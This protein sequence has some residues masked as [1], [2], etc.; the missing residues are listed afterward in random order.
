[1]HVQIKMAHP[2]MNLGHPMN[3]KRMGSLCAHLLV[4]AQQRFIAAL[5]A[6]MK[7]GW[8]LHI[9]LRG[10]RK[11]QRIAGIGIP[12]AGTLEISVDRKLNGLE[13]RPGIRKEIRGYFFL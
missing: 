1:M 13:T 11:I 7:Y 5:D 4:Q 3:G 10:Q 6:I 12:H 8:L 9:S 2:N